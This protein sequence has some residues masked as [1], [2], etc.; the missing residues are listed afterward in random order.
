M[1]DG[2]SVLGWTVAQEIPAVPLVSNYTPYCCLVLLSP[3][4]NS[5]FQCERSEVVGQAKGRGKRGRYQFSGYTCTVAVLMVLRLAGAVK[6]VFL[7]I[8]VF[9]VPEA[10]SLSPARGAKAPGCGRM[11]SGLSSDLCT[12]EQT[13]LQY[14]VPVLPRPFVAAAGADVFSSVH[15]FRVV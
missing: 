9:Q 3:R 2:R 8:S 10:L 6:Y 7:D 15:P 1:A 12:G 14:S 11:N 4:L 5:S 13:S